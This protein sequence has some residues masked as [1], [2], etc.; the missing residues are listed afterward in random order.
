MGGIFASLDKDDDVLVVGLNRA[1]DLL[2]KKLASVRTLG[3]HP[4]DKEPVLVRKGRFGPYA[5]HG[6]TVANLPRDV[7]MDDMTLEAAVALL[8]EKGKVLKAKGGAKKPKGRAAKPAPAEGAMAAK[9]PAAKK[10]APKKPAAK[11]PASK[12]KRP[13]A[14]KKPVAAKASQKPAA[15]AVKKPAA[16]A[17]G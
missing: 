2:A 11:K 3:G 1:V 8:A 6:N 10:A 17:T 16:E 15:K 12:A 9:A 5:Q 7:T 14:K 13:A 4:K